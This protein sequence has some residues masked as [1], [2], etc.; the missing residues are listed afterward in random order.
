MAW[1][2]RA[3]AFLW[4]G[5]FQTGL[6]DHIVTNFHQHYVDHAYD[7]YTT[8]DDLACQALYSDFTTV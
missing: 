2:E 6:P 5:G 4:R 1:I 3:W 7:S 8:A